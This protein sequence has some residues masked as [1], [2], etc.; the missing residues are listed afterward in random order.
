MHLTNA[1]LQRLIIERIVCTK[2]Y[3]VIIS[4]CFPGSSCGIT[5]Q[6]I[7]AKPGHMTFDL[8]VITTQNHVWLCSNMEA[9]HHIQ[10]RVSFLI[11]VMW[12]QLILVLET[13]EIKG[14]TFRFTYPSS[15]RSVNGLSSRFCSH[16]IA[17]YS[18]FYLMIQN[19]RTQYKRK[20]QNCFR[21]CK[22][23]QLIHD[24]CSSHQARR[25]HYI[26]L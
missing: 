24:P 9:M 12:S 20:D 25:T 22:G 15:R 7:S 19:T 17:G 2:G 6:A 16:F 11:S 18:F 5:Q 21:E 23:S 3:W 26:L 13:S 4:Q 10:R 14:L 8:T 1:H